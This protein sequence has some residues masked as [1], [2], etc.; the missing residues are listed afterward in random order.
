M[1][2]ITQVFYGNDCLPYKDKERTVHYTIAGT[3]FLGAS[4]TTKIKFYYD[5][6]DNLDETTW[7]AV[8]KLPN[9]KV[10]S[11]VLESYLDEELN[12]H[13]ALLELDSYYTQYKG[14]V[15]ISLQGYQGGVNLDYNEETSLYEIHGTPTIA[16]TGSIKFTINYANQFV[17]SGETDN[18][19]FQR[20]LADLGTKLGIRAKS[21]Y[22][23]ELPTVG[24]NDTFYVIND[25]PSEPNKANIYIWN[26][27]TKHYIWVGDNSLYLGDYYTKEEGET[28]ESGID[29][30]VLNIESQVSG[31]ASGSPKG[32]Y[33]T[34]SDLTTANPNHDYIYLV[35]ADG[36]WYYW[37]TSSS[38]WADGGAYLTSG[39]DSKLSFSSSNSVQ[40][41]KITSILYSLFQKEN[42]LWEI[43]LHLDKAVNPA[44]GVEF[45]ATGYYA[46]DFIE[47][48]EN[49]VMYSNKLD[50]IAFYDSSK[51][52]ISG[53][54]YLPYKFTTPAGAKYIKVSY[55]YNDVISTPYLGTFDFGDD[56]SFIPPVNGF[57]VSSKLYN[58]ENFV[59]GHK[60]YNLINSKLITDNKYVDYTNGALQDNAQYCSTYHIL[61]TPGETIYGYNAYQGAFYNS[62]KQYISGFTEITE[63]GITVP[64]NAVTMRVSLY[65][66]LY[67]MAYIGKQPLN[68]DFLPPKD[69]NYL[70]DTELKKKIVYVGV[71]GDF[72]SI[73]AALRHTPKNVK[74]FV[75]Y[76][77]YNIVQEYIDEYSSYFWSNY[78]GY[79]GVNDDFCKGLFIDNREIEF[80]PYAK[81]VWDYDGSNSAV[82]TY[83]AP[84]SLGTNATIKGLY[85]EF[86]NNCR[87]AIHDDFATSEGTNLVKDC[88]FVAQ[89]RTGG[90]TIGGGC[91]GYNTYIYENCLFYGDSENDISYHNQWAIGRNRIYVTNCK[92]PNNCYFGN[93]GNSTPS[94]PTYCV[95]SG[96]EFKNIYVADHTEGANQNMVLESFN[97][98]LT[99]E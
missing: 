50:L 61:V 62:Q 55:N 64:A 48:S 4:N 30:R 17:G 94:D 51:D 76:G 43:D 47:I 52:F 49:T 2:R 44:N 65:K 67:D 8:S 82:N 37:N 68:D 81:V 23:T 99:G 78:T 93:Y 57:M 18:V 90:T 9:G 88:I 86:N 70:Y 27:E 83:F 36:H 34:V 97:N 19:N 95:V 3:G 79:Q 29:S 96:C 35:L 5:E 89:N 53:L 74:I 1:S 84:F 75:G 56:F 32:V 59:Q 77:T 28:F 33:A 24:E 80:S 87:Y 72:T 6:L 16:A 40:N 92:G 73:L 98:T 42:L 69:K 85:L 39:A 20:I 7:V 71:G 45:N 63:S 15:F 60:T 46:T 14:D 22:V 10:G 13:Y 41:Q 66:P 54:D 25:D 31:I 58:D 91:N 11:R 26:N 12:E 38:E 21:E